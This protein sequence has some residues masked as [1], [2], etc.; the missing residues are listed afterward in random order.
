[1]GKYM[2]NGRFEDAGDIKPYM[3]L[4]QVDE[5]TAEE[6]MDMYEYTEDEIYGLRQQLNEKINE[7]LTINGYEPLEDIR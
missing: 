2:V 1:M 3:D 5:A 4:F 6:I 7:T